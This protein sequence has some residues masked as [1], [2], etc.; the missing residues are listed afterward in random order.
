[1]IDGGRASVPPVPHGD[2]PTII[3]GDPTPIGERTH[4][5]HG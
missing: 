1:M 5:N 3:G 2:L 4:G